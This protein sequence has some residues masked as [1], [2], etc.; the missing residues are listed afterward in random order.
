MPMRLRHSLRLVMLCAWL[1]CV[2]L[3]A[4]AVTVCTVSATALAFGSVS[5]LSSTA[6]TSTATVGVSCII[7]LSGLAA[8]PYTLSMGVS[9]TSGSM[10]RTMAGPSTTTLSYNVYTSGAYS[11]VW[12]NGSA[13]TSQI[14]GSVTPTVLGVAGSTSHTAYGKVPLPQA[15]K[16]G[17]YTDTIIVTVNY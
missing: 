7:T 14:S 2:A 11:S 10:T 4:G 15:V 1:L 17:S 13:G 3:P 5:S 16:P 8:V 12:G 6:A 9:S